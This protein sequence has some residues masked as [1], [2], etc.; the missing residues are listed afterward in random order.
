MNTRSSITGVILAGGMGRRMGG[1]DKGLVEFEGRPLIAHVMDTIA[2]QAAEI[3]V[4]ANRN[5]A[6]YRRFGHPVIADEL[7][8]FQGPLAGI[9]AAMEQ[10]TTPLLLVVPCDTPHVGPHLAQRLLHALQRDDADIA[11]AHNGQQMQPAHA[12]LATTL[13][14][15]IR[16]YLG[17]G[18]RG[19][20]RW[21]Q[22]HRVAI[23][24]F[25]DQ[26]ECFLNINTLE[27]LEELEKPTP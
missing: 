22:S 4:N 18:E 12:L 14:A 11:V 1:Q 24:D 6:A 5:I 10:S 23:A 15:D 25:S 26:A 27:Q 3:F 20:K 19:L 16:D 13:A 7:E 8:G 21:Q 17:R 9:L 2:P